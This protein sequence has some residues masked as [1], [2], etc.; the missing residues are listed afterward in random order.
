M[1]FCGVYI[2]TTLIKTV[3]PNAKEINMK[4]RK[5]KFISVISSILVLVFAITIVSA[6]TNNEEKDHGINFV[7]I[8][9]HHSMTNPNHLASV[10]LHCSGDCDS[11]VVY[12][13][14]YAGKRKKGEWISKI[15]HDTLYISKPEFNEIVESIA[16]IN[17]NDI[18]SNF[19]YI[20]IDGNYAD[21][22]YG[23]MGPVSLLFCYV[24]ELFNF[25]ISL[26]YLPEFRHAL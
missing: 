16:L 17:C 25:K 18:E 6:T 26:S 10:S 21:I 2:R 5:L 1:K 7:S 13:M 11:I 15:M 19:K 24:F 12:A 14:S 4:N 9:F 20:G 23:S 8:D 22:E 3:V